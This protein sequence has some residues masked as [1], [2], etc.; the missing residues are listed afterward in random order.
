MWSR[1]RGVAPFA[2]VC[3]LS[4][5][6]F[7]R[8]GT[9]APV[10]ASFDP[11]ASHVVANSLFAGTKGGGVLDFWGGSGGF[12]S[13]SGL[14]SIDF[15]LYALHYRESRNEKNEDGVSTT[16]AGLV[17]LPLSRR[18]ASGVPE[19]AL[20]LYFGFAPSAL[21]GG[22]SSSLALP[23]VI[24]IGPSFS[25]ERVT[26][27]PWVEGVPTL[28]I[29]PKIRRDAFSGNL[30]GSPA[31]QNLSD[32]QIAAAA[33]RAVTHETTFGMGLRYGFTAEMR[34][35]D[36]VD[37]NLVIAGSFLGAAFASP[38]M[39]EGGTGITWRWDHVARAVLPPE[40]RLTGESCDA[41]EARFAACPLY[42]RLV[43]ERDEAK[44]RGARCAP[45][46]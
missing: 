14:V 28:N 4:A 20:S 32:A 12:S 34:L 45:T 46:E 39:I 2:V 26:L 15:G 18:F 16:A 35:S 29:D 33:D 24:G 41:V 37:W 17:S 7:A 40:E 44:R 19:L 21:L 38:A 22:V 43:S 5:S 8:T 30:V 13:S 25:E 10:V 9:Q 36:E 11:R 3:L 23:A 1:A 31:A 42:G 6:A 27:T